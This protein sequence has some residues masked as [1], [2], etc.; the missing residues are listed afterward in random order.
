MKKWR[1]VALVEAGALFLVAVA[2]LWY[3]APHTN[4]HFPLPFTAEE[5]V[6]L[7]MYN[8]SSG[9]TVTYSYSEDPVEIASVCAVITGLGVEKEDPYNLH[10]SDG[11]SEYLF[12]IE[13]RS[14]GL[15]QLGGI[16]N[17]IPQTSIFVSNGDSAVVSG[18]DPWA[19][20]ALFSD[21]EDR[22]KTAS[23]LDEGLSILYQR[24]WPRYAS[25]IYDAG[26]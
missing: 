8:R 26:F 17:G 12:I 13:L 6:A 25:R 14:G 9:G 23:A 10:G 11:A 1:L 19:A 5:V 4:K 7:Q 24:C 21:R 16:H 3:F 18:L 15:Y 22:T 2:A 20:Q